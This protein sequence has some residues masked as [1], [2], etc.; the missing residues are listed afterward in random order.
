MTELLPDPRQA[1]SP[2]GQLVEEPKGRLTARDVL[3]VAAFVL[4]G[5]LLLLLVLGVF[6]YLLVRDYGGF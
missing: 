5:L 2:N 4:L 3:K 6:R 1:A